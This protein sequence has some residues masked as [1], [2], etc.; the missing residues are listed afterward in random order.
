MVFTESKSTDQFI[1]KSRFARLSLRETANAKLRLGIQALMQ[2]AAQR[3]TLL[4]FSKVP[5]GSKSLIR[6]SRSPLNCNVS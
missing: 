3:A 2:V 6:T 1:L 5:I 4:R